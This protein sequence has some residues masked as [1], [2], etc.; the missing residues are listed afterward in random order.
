[1]GQ[2]RGPDAI[3]LRKDAED[4]AGVGRVRGAL[5]ASGAAPG[6]TSSVVPTDVRPPW[7]Q[8]REG[9]KPREALLAA[10]LASERR[11][12]AFL[13]R[14]G[15]ALLAGSLDYGGTLARTVELGVPELGDL[16]LLDL[17]GPDR[18]IRRL[19]VAGAGEA[20]VLATRPCE[21]PPARSGSH[22]L[23]D[24]LALGKPILIPVVPEWLHAAIAA[25][26]TDLAEL[27]RWVRSYMCV[28]LVAGGR[29][30][31][32]ISFAAAAAGRFGEDELLLAE[33]LSRRAALALENAR[34]YALQRDI[35]HTLQQSL[36]PARLP[37]IP[38]LEIAARYLPG[39]EGH[40]VGGDFYDLFRIGREW[41]VV[42]G[43]VCGRGPQAA[44]LTALARHTIRADAA[45]EPTPRRVL[46]RL[47]RAVLRQD[48]EPRLMTVAYL[49]LRLG[50][51]RVD[52]VLA[53]GG[54]PPPLILR[55]D[56]RVEEVSCVGTLIGAF[57]EIELNERSLRLGPGD[58]LLLYTDG[59]TEARRAREFFGPGRLKALL[60]GCAG[61]S[62]AAIIERL[63]R[64]LADFLGAP[65]QDDIAMLVLRAFR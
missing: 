19:A 28:P 46:R 50:R 2:R 31:G 49:R 20:A 17:L 40:E 3:R 10:E 55:C 36:L 26:G 58:A 35:A 5:R 18:S 54:H 43:D 14:V 56:G 62:A 38:G 57:A 11:R 47:N 65:G 12:L 52:G 30:L 21:H 37:E 27:R 4:P 25:E 64:G 51:R 16:C 39:G 48:H 24:V 1:M 7:R 33:E 6:Q 63:E 15:A 29:I 34:L 8:S 42:M 23:L 41:A 22:P 13:A 45:Y 60:R 44:A 59:L 61:L 53:S 9:R 32:A